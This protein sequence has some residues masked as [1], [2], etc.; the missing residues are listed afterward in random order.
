MLFSKKFIRLNENFSTF[1]DHVPAPMFRREFSVDKPVE[2]CILTITALGLYDLFFNG[3]KITKGYFAP[4]VSAPTDLVYYDTYDI[5]QSLKNG[6]NCVGVIVGTGFQND[7]GRYNWRFDR[8][9]QL[10]MCLLQH[11]HS[12]LQPKLICL[13]EHRFQEYLHT[14]YTIVF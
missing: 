10:R 4:Y 8:T 7:V 9:V 14:V 6:Q 1:Y 12:V 2:S 13:P 5:T 11:L 3:E